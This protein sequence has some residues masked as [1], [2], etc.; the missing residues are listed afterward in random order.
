MKQ[1][2]VVIATSEQRVSVLGKFSSEK[3]KPN[4]CKCYTSCTRCK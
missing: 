2:N 3:N 1:P 4:E